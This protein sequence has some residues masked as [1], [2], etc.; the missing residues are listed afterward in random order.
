MSLIKIQ[1]F[2]VLIKVS[3]RIIFPEKFKLVPYYGGPARVPRLGGHSALYRG[4]GLLFV[5][6]S[7]PGGP[8]V[9][10]TSSSTC[11][12]PVLSWGKMIGQ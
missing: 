2:I 1:L 3:G 9:L 4:S 12:P 10:L 5:I 11:E 8:L 6:I 7:T